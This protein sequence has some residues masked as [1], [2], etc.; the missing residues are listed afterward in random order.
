MNC[1]KRL[2]TK[3]LLQ[4]VNP[5]PHGRFIIWALQKSIK[6]EEVE[7]E[8]VNVLFGLASILVSVGPLL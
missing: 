8:T 5:R 6:L 1:R 2:H 7:S 3:K 4:D